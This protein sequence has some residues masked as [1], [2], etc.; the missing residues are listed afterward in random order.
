MLTTLNES[1]LA[2]GSRLRV[3]RF[4]TPGEC[5]SRFIE[6]QIWSMGFERWRETAL[7]HHYWRLYYRDHLAND[8]SSSVVDYL[9]FAEVDGVLCSRL[10]F[11][12]SRRSGLGNFGNV[13]TEPAYRRRG[14]MKALLYPCV[15][16]FMSS[17]A[18]MLCC[19]AG[20]G[21]AAREYCR[22]GFE[23]IY[24]GEPGTGGP[25]SLHRPD[26]GRF[27]D[28]AS[29]RFAGDSISLVRVGEA[30]DQFDVDKFLYYIP[31]MLH[32]PGDH[33]AFAGMRIQD[34]RFVWQEVLNGNGVVVVAENELGAIVGYA[35]VLR[36]FTGNGY[37][38]DFRLHPS[39]VADGSRL[40][41][42]ALSRFRE[43][44]GSSNPVR[45]YVISCD[46]YKVELSGS[47]FDCETVLKDAE[48]AGGKPVDVMVFKSR[49]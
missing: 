22:A 20:A 28:Y 31:E 21:H 26:L 16:D 39:Y 24:G 25:M 41:L 3:Y 27:L 15:E 47:V 37:L 11:A 2:G 29:S 35:Y 5:P 12:Y 6:Y 18:L 4:V 34:Y 49:D 9:Y 30:G 7:D 13:F 14:L 44:T 17:D 48:I 1:Q 43:V 23:Q 36:A 19:G 42:G 32:H 46:A 45:A 8:V 10:W 38:L 33:R 40:L